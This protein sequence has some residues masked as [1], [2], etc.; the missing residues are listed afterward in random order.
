MLETADTDAFFQT[1]FKT[2]IQ[3]T[4][5]YPPPPRWSTVVVAG[6]GRPAATVGPTESPTARGEGD[7]RRPDHPRTD[8][9]AAA[10]RKAI[11]TNE[12]AAKTT[13]SNAFE[14]F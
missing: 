7:D 2:P 10:L 12:P 8:R 4:P 13:G 3:H 9:A 14:V 11:H 1:P 6:P 5:P